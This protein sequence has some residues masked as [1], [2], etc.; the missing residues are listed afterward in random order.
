MLQCADGPHGPTLPCRPNP[1]AQPSCPCSHALQ[2]SSG[3][4]A[5]AGHSLWESHG[6]RTRLGFP[7]SQEDLAR[8]WH[9][10]IM[11]APEEAAGGAAEPFAAQRLMLDVGA[12]VGKYALL[13]RVSRPG[14]S[15]M[16]G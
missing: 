15:S 6:F 13:P 1:S 16:R 2:R 9:L 4:S 10:H 7:L 5:L 8:A 11:G 14:A 12:N 3:L